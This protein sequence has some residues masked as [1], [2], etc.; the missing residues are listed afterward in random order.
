M[1]LLLDEDREKMLEKVRKLLALSQSPNEHEAA[2]AAERAQ[3]ILAEYNLTMA[4]ALKKGQAAEKFVVDNE[5]FTKAAPWQ[6]SLGVAVATLYFCSYLFVRCGDSK[7]QNYF[8]GEKHNTV[9]AKMMFTYLVDTIRRLSREGAKKHPSQQSAYKNS[10]RSACSQRVAGRIHR[11]I[12]ESKRGGVKTETGTTLPALA[13]LY[14]SVKPKLDS[15][16]ADEIGPTKKKSQRLTMT[17][18]AGVMDGMRAGDKIGLDQQVAGRGNERLLTDAWQN[19]RDLILKTTRRFVTGD[20]MEKIMVASYKTVEEIYKVV[21]RHVDDQT[22]E[23]IVDE[24]L[25]VAGNK[26]FRE[27]IKRLA[28]EDAKVDPAL[29]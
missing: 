22:M 25:Q 3:A 21:R 18:G 14:D 11:R 13:S 7:D 29:S 17:H 5:L 8:V 6:R 16:I 4:D 12:E 26:S 15:F 1:T 9:V 24:L 19:G 28:A 23:K 10:F 2:L 20:Q 27:T